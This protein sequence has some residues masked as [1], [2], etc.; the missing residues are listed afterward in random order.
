L[1]KIVAAAMIAALCL[2]ACSG[3]KPS[4]PIPNKPPETHLFLVMGDS[5]GVADTTARP[6]TSV[7][8]LVLHWYGDDSDGEV[9][10]YQWAWDDTSS[11]T[12]WTY[13]DQV[14]DTFYVKIR[15]PFR[16]FTFYV[17]SIDSD[18]ALDPTPAFITFPIINSPPSIRLPVALVNDYSAEHSTTFGYQ[19]ITWSSSD[20][21]GDETISGYEIALADSSFHWNPDTTINDTIRFADLDWEIVLDSLTFSFTFMDL[22]PGCYRMFLR[23]F[24][25]TGSRSDVVYYPE[26]TGVWQVI[27]AHGD[28]LYI[29][30]NAYY[31][32]NDTLY[33]HFLDS[34]GLDY[35][36]LS[37]IQRPFY[38]AQD[39]ALGLDEFNILIY[40]AGET[41]HL[42]EAGPVLANFVNSGGH[43]MI[44]SVSST[45]DTMSYSFMP[46]DSI[47]DDYV[48]RPFRFVQPDSQD[49]L[50]GYPVRL[51][52][53]QV[54][55]FSK[56]FGFA[57][58]V[59]DGINGS[60]YK[61]LYTIEATVGDP[62]SIGDTVAVRFPYNP[63][64]DI[65]EPA[66]VIFFSFP[67]F[68][69][70]VN[71][72]FAEIYSHILLNEFTDE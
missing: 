41:R 23:C 58:K 17:R 48:F 8:T 69:C 52:T 7:S 46:I 28:I 70:N 16:F 15:E 67:V 30:D 1:K 62:A 72:G 19:T 24:D 55:S 60:G 45:T 63:D 44:N 68:D 66:K 12:A 59:P 35:T 20:P 39:F 38:Y 37:F 36:A 34:L 4:N 29:D 3:K 49:H 43:L 21:D 65:Q 31:T 32:S 54:G 13:T 42:R 53:S 11:D 64:V 5:L 22:E 9:I 47:Y 50:D 27:E 71:H 6:D 57:P 56:V 18:S 51:E 33:T 40:N 10:G 26:T 14:F 2:L 25:I 61:V